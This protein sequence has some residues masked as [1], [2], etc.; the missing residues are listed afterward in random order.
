MNKVIMVLDDEVGVARLCQ[1]VLERAGFE[2][3]CVTNPVQGLGILQQARVD[4][5]LID[6]RMPKMDGFQVMEQARKYQPEL[7]IVVMTGYGTVETAIQ[8]LRLGANGLLLKPFAKT[9]ELVESVNQALSERER[10]R[11]MS[12]LAALQPIIQVTGSLFAETRTEPLLE[13]IMDAVVT[14][15][16]CA[17]AGFYQR[18]EQDFLQLLA[19][20]G[21]PFPGEL[22]SLE[23]G[24]LSR[25]DLWNVAIQI[26]VDDVKHVDSQ[27]LLL[28]Y[29]FG[30]VMCAPVSRGAEN[31]SVLLAARNHGEP[32]FSEADFEMFTILSRQAATALDNARLYTELRGTIRQLEESQLKLIQAEK[33]AA[34]GRLTA[35][36]A[37]EVNNPL[38]AV[39]N[40]LHLVNREDLPWPKRM[41]YLATANSE[42]E[43]LMVTMRQ[44][45]DFSRPSTGDRTLTNVNALLETV[46]LLI[47]KQL[48]KQNIQVKKRF[49][50]NLPNVLV[51][52]NQ[53]QQVFLNI[54]LN[55]ME[56]MLDGGKIEIQSR[57]NGDQV[58]IFFTD[59]GPGI[60]EEHRSQIFEPFMSTKNQGTGL[61]LS[62]SYNI[63]EAHGGKL[64]LMPMGRKQ[65]RGA[66]FRVTLP[67]PEAT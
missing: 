20:R 60:P 47:D 55:A 41:E 48:Q 11:E 8:A 29:K 49:G 64:E 33:M 54:I 56:V 63:M 9:A 4:L 13:L 38:Q 14:H 53:I 17:H 7:A 46:L 39:R 3:I 6:I 19:L 37:H 18:D 12:R 57:P 50:Q 22:S 23:G 58:E 52:R 24:P 28:Q 66:C 44:M 32:S 10:Q 2:V 26:N 34:L 65:K 51:A 35:S 42:V 15:L 67:I 59:S 61:G 30:S 36:I 31:R 21:A 16:H 1:Q 25:A 5:L 43:R 40:C 27:G 62:V 45:L